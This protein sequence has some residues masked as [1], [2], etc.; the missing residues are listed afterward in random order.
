MS[1]SR[2]MDQSPEVASSLSGESC[3]VGIVVLG[4]MEGLMMAELPQRC[5]RNGRHTEQSLGF[6]ATVASTALIVNLS[7]DHN[8]PANWRLITAVCGR[9][10]VSG[11]NSVLQ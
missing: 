4:D 6:G 10:D 2:V 9:R 1:T 11:P 8:K 7:S 5:V 3:R